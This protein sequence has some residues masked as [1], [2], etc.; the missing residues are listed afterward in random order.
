MP[1]AASNDILDPLLNYIYVRP[2]IKFDGQCLKQNKVTFTH[3][4][5]VNIYIV[6][7]INLWVYKHN[8]GFT[9]GNS[10]FGAVKSTKNTDC[11]KC[12]YSVY[13]IGFNARGSVYHSFA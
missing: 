4:N 7:E 5:V 12:K 6:Y 3:K 13:C 2:I 10:L 11:D 8:D 9:L 1:S